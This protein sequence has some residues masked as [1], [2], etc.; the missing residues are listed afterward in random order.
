M[1]Y[2]CAP[3]LQ[4]KIRHK[5]VL[6]DPPDD[7]PNLPQVALIWH[8]GGFCPTQGYVK[9]ATAIQVITTKQLFLLLL[10]ALCMIKCFMHGFE[11]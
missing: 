5:T 2:L 8:P 9:L 10:M 7:D 6:A 3:V 11:N 4:H 1:Q